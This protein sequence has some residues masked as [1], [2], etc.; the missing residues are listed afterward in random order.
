M[1]IR[2]RLRN[3]RGTKSKAHLTDLDERMPEPRIRVGASVVVTPL[4]SVAI[5]LQGS[6][7]NVSTRGLRVHFDTRLNEQPRA[8]EIYRVQ[9]R[10]DLLLC[11][12]CHCEAAGAGTNLD[13]QIIN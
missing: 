3:G 7:V 13:L 10:D 2:A 9:S 11:E 4:A 8:G 6:V 5:R 12:V 1:I